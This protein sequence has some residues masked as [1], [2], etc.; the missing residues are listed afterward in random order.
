[1]L[2]LKAQ[3]GSREALGRLWDKITP[4]LFGYLINVTKNEALAEDVLQNT[5]LKA[6]EALPRFE[7]RGISPSAWLF[8]IAKNECREHW[9]KTARETDLNLEEHDK[10]A[11][12]SLN[13]EDKFLIEKILADLSEEDRELIRLRYIADLPVNDIARIL[14]INFVAVRVRLHRALVRARNNIVAKKLTT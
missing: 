4:K 7:T 13:F 2:I 10:A 12:D 9:R 1:M 5:W 14:N 8:A 3:K 11:D 6:I